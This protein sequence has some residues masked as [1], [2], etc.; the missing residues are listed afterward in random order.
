MLVA[1][2]PEEVPETLESLGV[3]V[4]AV[5]HPIPARQRMMITKPRIVLVGSAVRGDDFDVLARCAHHVGA[6]IL[7]L[8][9]LVVRDRLATWMR[10]VMFGAGES[11][12]GAG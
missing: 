10:E 9:P 3:A 2:P 5:R 1:V 11:G 12:Q 8:G 6:D 7:Q 4:I